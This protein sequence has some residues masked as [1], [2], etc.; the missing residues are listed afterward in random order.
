MHWR[1]VGMGKTAKTVAARRVRS[2]IGPRAKP[3][4]YLAMHGPVEHFSIQPQQ[5]V[6]MGGPIQTQ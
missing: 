6:P 1:V 3:L 2:L 4:P 5:I